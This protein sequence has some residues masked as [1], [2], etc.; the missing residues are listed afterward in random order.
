MKVVILA[1]WEWT[2][3]KPLTNNIPKLLIKIY[4]KSI[5]EHN[6]ENLKKFAKQFIIVVSKKNEEKIKNSLWNEYKKIKIKYHIQ[7][8][9]KW[10]AAAIKDLIIKWDFI[11]LYG[12][13][14]YSE[15]DIKKV[16]KDENYWC[17]VK[18]VEDPK[19]YWIFEADK[20]LFAKKVVEKPVRNIWN[21]ANMWWFKFNEKIIELARKTKKSK[22]WEY[23]ITES[24]N[25][26]LK[27]FKFKLHKINED[28]IDIWY[29]WDILS[30]N[31][32][33]LGK[34]KESKIKSKLEKNV[35]IKW[36]VIVE[37]GV[38]LKSWT[39]IEWNC[40]I[41]AGSVIWP[42][43]YIRWNTV[44]WN[45]CKVWNAVEIKNSSL[46]DNT[47]VAHLSYIWDSIIWNNVNIWWW[48]IVANLRHDEKNIKV[49]FKLELKDSWLRKFWCV[50]WDNSKI[51]IWTKIYPGRIIENDTFT[52]PGE[53]IK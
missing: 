37:K 41:W 17:L 49:L 15:E 33:F 47:N 38:T 13:S 27:N 46:W 12:D 39:Y 28:I 50:I 6:L 53:V 19:R 9:D 48:F 1:A 52:I 34:L 43:C 11:I 25:A 44:I 16:I 14:I 36:N 21:L 29:P 5:I 4:W 8:T 7:W 32:Y 3:L 42:N 35:I 45:N 10:T 26:F 2:R 31:K 20:E 51:W 22:R 30:A 23:E 24:L 18:K 40:Y